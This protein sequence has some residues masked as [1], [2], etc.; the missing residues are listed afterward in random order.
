MAGLERGVRPIGDWSMSMTLSI[1]STPSSFLYGPTTRLERCTAL[2][3]AGASVSVTS[4]LLP[5]PETP[6]TTVSVPSSILA[7][8]FLR[9]FA[10]APV[11]LICPLRG[12]RR[13]S[14]RR[15]WRSPVR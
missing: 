6:V 11:I 12:L 9:L 14:G 1:W 13:F 8:T 4:E 2:V 7:E 15:I 10:E 3:S 5:E